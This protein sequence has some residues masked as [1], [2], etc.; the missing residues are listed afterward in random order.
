MNGH[1][2]YRAFTNGTNFH[3]SFHATVALFQQ[4]LMSWFLLAQFIIVTRAENTKGRAFAARS[5][6]DSIVQSMNAQ[7]FPQ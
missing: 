4:D 7:Q 2:Y 6:S 3:V 5:G 1:Y